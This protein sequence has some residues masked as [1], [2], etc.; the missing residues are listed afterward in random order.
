MIVQACFDKE[1][2]GYPPP[3][4]Q[5]EKIVELPAEEFDAFLDTPTREL[6]FI[7]E[8]SDLMYSE[9]GMTHC[10][11]VLGQDRNDGVLVDAEGCDYPKYASFLF[12]A[13]DIVNAEIRQ[14]AEL[15]VREGVENTTEGNWCF[16]F[17]ELFEQM[18][19]VVREDNGIGGMIVDEL[20]RRPEVD[21]VE[22][23]HESFD[24]V[25]FPEYC[26]HLRQ[27][28]VA[29]AFRP[30]DVL[31]LLEEFRMRHEHKNEPGDWSVR[32]CE[33]IVAS[34]AGFHDRN[35]W[36]KLLRQEP[37]VLFSFQWDRGSFASNATAWCEE[38]GWNY[39]FDTGELEIEVE[40]EWRAVDYRFDYSRHTEVFLRPELPEEHLDR[41]Q[42]EDDCGAENQEE[43][44]AWTREQIGLKCLAFLA[45]HDGSEELY[46][47]LHS[48]LGLANAEI[49]AL[50]FDLSHR[51][52]DEP[53]MTQQQI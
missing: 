36:T 24:P 4:C 44:P 20:N 28:E 42:L 14:A 19:L 52:E 46:Q 45:E 8:N 41:R 2:G 26:K 39:R 29:A 16:Y 1:P 18:G 23:S 32:M 3:R 33:A 10:L 31:R 12:G 25:F 11:L 17:D 30:L 6:A 50:G 43:H 49:E 48:E 51:F 34:E 35:Q 27:E 7:A 15:I 21:V 22:I 13:R 38:N 53:G 47:M 9:A 37:P 5:V 40:G